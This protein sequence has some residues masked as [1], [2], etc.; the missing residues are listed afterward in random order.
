M[1]VEAT[2]TE[3]GKED[4]TDPKGVLFLTDQRILFEQK[5][6]IATKKFLFITTATEKVQK[7]LWEFH[8]ALFNEGIATKQ[9][10]FKNQDFIELRLASGAPYPVVTLHLHGQDSE[11][12]VVLIKRVKAHELDADRA[13]ALDQQ[14]IEKVKQAPSLCPSCGG[15]ISKPILRGQD[16]ITC[17]FCGAVIR[18]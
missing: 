1:A 8:V 7:L 18:L 17:E 15:V 5:Q 9:G 6:E 2:W 10:L 4:N 3:N 11:S 12:W 13:I 16:Q 14:V